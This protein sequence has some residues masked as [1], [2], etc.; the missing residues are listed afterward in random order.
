MI[1]YLL[2][3]CCSRE[4]CFK[5]RIKDFHDG[6]SCMENTES[7]DHS[8]VSCPSCGISLTKGDGCNTITCVCGKQFSWSTEKENTERCQQFLTAFPS[9]TSAICAAVLCTNYTK[10][11]HPRNVYRL[12]RTMSVVF[13]DLQQ[14]EVANSR[15]VSSGVIGQA[16]A[17][18][19][20]H[21]VDVS[22]EMREL[23][24][25]LHWPSPSQCCATITSHLNPAYAREEGMREAAD[26]WK[27]ENQKQVAKCAA[28]NAAAIRSLMSTF[29]PDEKERAVAAFKLLNLS[30][31]AWKQPGLSSSSQLL[32][33]SN[34]FA[35]DSRLVDSAKHWTDQNREFY[36]H[37][38]ERFEIRSASQF[39]YLYGSRNPFYTRPAYTYV[40]TVSEWCRRTSNT[41]LTYTN[42]NTT[43]ERV[44]SISCYPAAFAAVV[45]DHCCFRVTLDNAPKSSNWI[46]FGLARIG[47]ASSSSDGVGRTSNTWGLSDDR[48]SS[49]SNS[50][51]SASGQESGSFRKLKAGDIL[52]ATVYLS[53]GNLEISVNDNELLH[54]FSIPPGTADEYVFAMTFANDHRVSILSDFSSTKCVQAKEIPQEIQPAA[55]EGTG[56]HV[57]RSPQSIV[58]NGEQSQMLNALRKQLRAI[59]AHLNSESTGSIPAMAL[60]SDANKWLEL[61]GGTYEDAA[62]NYQQISGHI[63]QLLHFRRSPSAGN[64]NSN[65]NNNLAEEGRVNLPWLTWN[66][67]IWALSWFKENKDRIQQETNTMLAHEF[68]MIHG[69]DAPFMAAMNLVEYHTHK[70]DSEQEV[71]TFFSIILLLL[72]SLLICYEIYL[73]AIEFGG[74]FRSLRWRS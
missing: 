35:V 23:F 67:V 19:L 63:E 32:F 57:L 55:N 9:N 40:P 73:L 33:A 59:L 6:K 66:T 34:P 4:H 25:T 72:L 37:E 11:R 28:Q 58:L 41:D 44:G 39:L 31:L 68:Y 16:K 36:G 10:V 54:R 49:S 18:Q 15:P 30:R 38:V 74:C 60:L 13:E 71:T 21:R 56:G 27:A 62:R 64:G 12:K 14:D 45:A 43:V 2:T 50:I 65:S 20:R 46:S 48:S 5:C 17:W 8:V 52:T 22:R 69:D 53:D 42:D 29:Y 51:L 24:E 61:S 70:V 7:L 1:I 47:M 26:I 3:A